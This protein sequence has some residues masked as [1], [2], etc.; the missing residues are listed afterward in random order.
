MYF[1]GII[2]ASSKNL[3]TDSEFETIVAN[4][5]RHGNTRLNRLKINA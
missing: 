2:K 1:L 4:W 3:M 5:F